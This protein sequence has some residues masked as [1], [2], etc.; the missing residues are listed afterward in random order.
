MKISDSPLVYINSYTIPELF[1][2]KGFILRTKPYEVNIIAIRN[3]DAVA[4]TF[5][6]L[7]L[8]FYYHS[9]GTPQIYY[10]PCTTDAGLYYRLNPANVEG[11]AIIAPGQNL[12]VYKIGK[13]KGYEAME[14]V[15]P[16]NYI[17]DNNKNK[18]LDWFTNL[19]GL[20]YVKEIAKTNIHHAG[21]DSIQV[22]KWSAGCIVLKKIADFNTFMAIIRES[23]FIYKNENLFDLTL[24]NEEDFKSEK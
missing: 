18:I 2:A 16:I 9:N 14:Q 5:N 12:K 7:L 6:D 15:A 3:K 17:R 4:N 13:H 21:V 22:D 11:T 24:L 20:K 10:W 8:I 19:V 23:V 1:K